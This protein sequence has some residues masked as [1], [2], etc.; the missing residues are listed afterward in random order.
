MTDFAKIT[1]GTLPAGTVTKFGTVRRSGLT[2]YYIGREG[3]GTWVPFAHIHGTP[4][5]VE[6]LVVFG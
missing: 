1:P 6:S 4:A 3:Q 2:A 5:P